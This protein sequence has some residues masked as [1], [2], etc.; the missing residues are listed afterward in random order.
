MR[1]IVNMYNL[2]HSTK[3]ITKCVLI[4]CKR[5]YAKF[6]QRSLSITTTTHNYPTRLASSIVHLRLLDRNCLWYGLD[7]VL[8]ASMGAVTTDTLQRVL[9]ICTPITNLLLKELVHV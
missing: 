1:T 6:K 4:L 2:S 8:A 5:G 7:T 3:S 9:L